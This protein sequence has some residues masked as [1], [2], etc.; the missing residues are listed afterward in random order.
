M[1]YEISLDRGY[2]NFPFTFFFIIQGKIDIL[3]HKLQKIEFV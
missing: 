3:T 2:G 1:V